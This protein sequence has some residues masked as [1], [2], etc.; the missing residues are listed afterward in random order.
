LNDILEQFVHG[1]DVIK[2]R[3][4]LIPVAFYSLLIWTMEGVL[5]FAI[6]EAF[7]YSSTIYL[8][9]FVLVVVNLGIMIPSSPGYV[10]TFEYFCTKALGVFNVTKESA[11]S[12]ALVLRIFQYIPI[13]LVGFFFLFK[14]GITLSQMM[15]QEKSVTLNSE[16]K[17][18]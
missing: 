10:G 18:L 2:D 6:A 16:E 4:S 11:V 5:F 8:A 15:Q 17:A 12:Y 13:T 9:L 7:D 3:K 1:F 14:E